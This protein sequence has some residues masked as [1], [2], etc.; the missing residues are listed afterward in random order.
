MRKLSFILAGLAFLVLAGVAAAGNVHYASHPGQPSFVDQGTNLQTTVDVAGLGNFN[1]EV[2]ITAS[3]N[4]SGTSVCTNNGGNAAPGQNPAAFPVT[5]AGTTVVPGSDIKN[6]RVQISATAVTTP[7]TFTKAG[8][9]D[10]ANPG[11][12][13][14]VTI[15]NVA[16]TSAS[17]AI[18]QD[19]NNNGTFEEAAA[20]SSGCSFSPATSDGAVPKSSITC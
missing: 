17:V 13:E 3:G 15:T 5:A 7:L 10:C 11:W 8:A 9:P 6:G 20:L 16:W 1:T 14:T 2:T 12:T 18:I 4:A 19:T